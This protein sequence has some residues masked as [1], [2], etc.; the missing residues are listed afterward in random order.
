MLVPAALK[1]PWD[2]SDAVCLSSYFIKFSPHP[3]DRDY[4][5]FGLFVKLPLPGEAE[6]MKLNLHLALGRSVTTEL[7]PS[8]VVKFDKEE[9][10]SVYY[11]C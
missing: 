7:V 2:N 6:R 4:K 3:V 9:V 8:T 10:S 1:E 5:P 11:S